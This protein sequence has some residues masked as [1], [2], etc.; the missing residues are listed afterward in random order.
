MRLF[1]VY[2]FRACH[3]DREEFPEEILIQGNSPEEID[4]I[5]EKRR[6]E[7]EYSDDSENLID[8]GDEHQLQEILFFDDGVE[9]IIEND[10]F[11]ILS[12]DELCEEFLNLRDKNEI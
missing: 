2:R 4:K 1:R 7:Y 6:E 8:F 10:K 9:N 3:C 12:E 5:I 11:K